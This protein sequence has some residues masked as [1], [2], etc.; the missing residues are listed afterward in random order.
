MRT[1]GTQSLGGK[2]TH[3]SITERIAAVFLSLFLAISPESMG[4]DPSFS[5]GGR[6]DQASAGQNYQSSG[7][8]A[9]GGGVSES[10]PTQ[11][12]SA[13]AGG[14]A[15]TCSVRAKGCGIWYPSAGASVGG[16]IR[17]ANPSVLAHF[18][19][20]GNS[21]V[22]FNLPVSASYSVNSFRIFGIFNQAIG[23]IS[24]GASA[25]GAQVAGTAN[26]TN[27][28]YGHDFGNSGVFL[29]FPEEGGS[30]STSLPIFIT[31]TGTTSVDIGF[32]VAVD[33]WTLDISGQADAIAHVQASFTPTLT[34]SSGN[35]INLGDNGIEI[36][37]Q[38]TPTPD[39][40]GDDEH[41]PKGCGPASPMA[42]YNFHTMLASLVI[43]DTP[44]GYDPPYGYS[45]PFEVTYT[46]RET[47]QPATFNYANLGPKWNINWLSY[48]TD[49]PANFA[50]VSRQAR[51]GG[52]SLPIAFVATSGGYHTYRFVGR[53]G[54]QLRRAV[55]NPLPYEIL[56]ADGSKEIYGQP[57]ASSSGLRK[58]FLT[59]RIDPAGNVTTIS[60]DAQMRITRI[61]D[62]IGQQVTL[63]YGLAS[64]PLKI[65]KVTDP[66]GRFATFDYDAAGRLF[67][68]TDAIGIQSV[69]TYEGASDFINSLTTPYGTTTFANTVNGHIRRMTATD[70][71]GDTEVLE[72]NDLMTSGIPYGE[73]ENLIPTGMT[74]FHGN[75]GLRNSFYWDKKRWREAPNDYNKAHIYH[76]L[77][78][79]NS[80]T[81]SG[82]LESEK[83]P[84]Q[85]RIWYNYPAQPQPQII[86]RITTPSKIGRVIEGGTQLTSRGITPLGKISSETDPV[87]RVT[88]FAY[89]TD[90]FDLTGV[91]QNENG[92]PAIL[93]AFEYNAQHRPLTFTDAAAKVTSYTWNAVG[94]IAS[95]RNAK[96]ETTSFSYYA[97]DA[98][99]K[100]RKG[101]LS[102]IDGALAGNSDVVTFDYDATG[103]VATVTGPDGYFL[104]FSY[105][106]LNRL[107]R[108]TFPDDSYTETTYLALDPQTSRDRLGRLTHYVYNSIRQLVAVTDP[109]QRQIRYGYCDCGE[110]D[111]LIDAMGRITRWRHDL[112]G[113]VTAKIYADGSTINYG[114]EPLSGRLSTITD[115]KHQV[116]TRDYNLDNTLAGINYTNTEHPTPNV[117]FTYDTDFRRLKSMVDGIGTTN[118]AY[119]PIA[120][121]TLGAGRLASVDGPLA[122]D[123]L[124]YV[125]DELS[126]RTSYAIN[127]VGETRSFDPL[128][129]LLSAVNP[130]GTFGYTYVGATSRIDTVN[131]PNGMTCQ[132]SYH[133]LTGDFRL[134]DIIHT[135]P[136]NTLL[137]RHSYE[138]S[139]VGNIIRWTQISPQAGLNRS[140]L[141]GYDNADQLTSVASQ[142]P[143]TLVNQPTGQYAYGYD[144]AGNR[145]IETIDGVTTT[146]H[147]NA[148]NQLTGLEIGGVSIPPNQT[149]E[150]DAEDR[151][152]AIRY[153]G[154]N[155]RS[156]LEYDGYGRRL[157]V[158]EKQDAVVI[159]YRRF[160]WRGLQV[161]E[162]RDAS[163][164][165]V[166]KRYLGRGMQTSGMGG[167]LE[168][169]M[170]SCDHLG[171]VRELVSTASALTSA[172]DFDPWGRRSLTEGS[173]DE[174]SLAFTGHWFHSRSDL[175]TAPYRGYNPTL[176][177][178]TTRD[179]IGEAG[180]I[181]LYVY[182]GNDPVGRIDPLGLEDPF[183]SS[184]WEG[185]FGAIGAGIGGAAGTVWGPVILG[186][187]GAVGGAIIGGG[188]E[189][190]PA[191]IAGTYAG[192]QAGRKF[193]GIIGGALGGAIGS[194]LG[195]QFDPDPEPPPPGPWPPIPTEPQPDLPPP[196]WPPIPPTPT[197]CSPQ[198]WPPIPPGIPPTPPGPPPWWDL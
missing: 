119:Y 165:V 30:V 74:V 168:S 99:G 27:G 180:G 143:I 70:P 20:P 142:D 154:T 172:Y 198:P 43:K 174:S 176:G 175:A 65:T 103:N 23:S 182:L 120:P 107:T 186:G 177:R 5:A 39:Y 14:S 52:G 127:G 189:D 197:C 50:L 7:P 32:S 166:Q 56:N 15:V 31:P 195:K 124:T 141:C 114:Y 93:A 68:I 151:L 156:E 42:S 46:Q 188:P 48:I 16:V 29:G 108:V 41:K 117:V 83:P 164:S 47:T 184:S 167:A 90:G 181:G 179:P 26:S 102:Q 173:S 129:R 3:I 13:S 178:W 71:A 162:E 12:Y 88:N 72:S 44:V 97:S 191:V 89:S 87:G 123:T 55:D 121:G 133:P 51:P 100:Q 77:L 126:R 40:S 86:G 59:Q 150:W 159:N 113:R 58:V 69:F 131:Y 158:R 63:A 78:D 104:R 147:Y 91:S 18:L 171:S 118:Y 62:A 53:P 115:E 22:Q 105:D 137:S 152:A 60:Y 82:S 8:N 111:Q 61:T 135:L 153:T 9:A 94:Q 21:Q 140:W 57:E 35:P 1:C 2:G 79:E 116:K 183:G 139:A 64:D 84:L 169:R 134:K 148:L 136:G 80:N 193:G 101:R 24:F 112:A 75:L 128:G 33:G 196:P 109:A 73:S 19:I 49:N 10:I 95:V 145:L 155:D 28:P 149:Y 85:S 96:N 110:M 34:D 67:K 76:W 106:A 192:Q 36:L 161:V 132:Y 146:A 185:T 144:P 194:K 11:S 157:G 130:L 187:L 25:P 160:A 125:Y 45:M 122:N 138:Y 17:I 66:F 38:P 163:G 92:A 54:M 37:P 98:A 4:A 81:M 170:Y 190:V 6:L